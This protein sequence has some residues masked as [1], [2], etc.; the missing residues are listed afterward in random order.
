MTDVVDRATRSRMMAGIRGSNTKPELLLRK[1]LHALG[2]RYRLHAKELPGRPD[3]VF[4][5]HEAAVFVHGCFWHRHP[6]CRLTTT[7]GTRP[8]FWKEKFRSNVDRDQRNLGAL[9][10]AGWRTAVVW[11]CALRGDQVPG[12]VQTVSAWLVGD[13]PDLDVGA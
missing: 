9:R 3:L 12:T 1:G 7:P 2:F 10:E 11:E 6:G 13:T 5:K 8:D 4:P